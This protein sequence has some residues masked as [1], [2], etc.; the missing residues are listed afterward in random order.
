MQDRLAESRAVGAAIRQVAGYCLAL[1]LMAILTACGNRPGPQSLDPRVVDVPGARIVSMYVAT[2]R[3]RVAPGVNRFTDAPSQTLNFALYRVSIPPTHKP[4]QIEYPGDRPNPKTD[5]VVVDQKPLDKAE[6]LRGISR[7]SNGAK[8]DISLFVHGFNTS[9][10]EA[11]F[12][13]AQLTADSTTSSN[14][15]SVLFA[16]PSTASYSGYLADKAAAT[17][18]RDQLTEL[19]TLVTRERPTG[20]ILVAAH[21]MGGWL[22]M[23]AL[24]QLK[25]TGKQ[26]VLD[27]LKVILA[28]PDIDGMIFLA[29]MQVIGRMREPMTI[30]VSQDDIALSISSFISQDQMRIGLIN[31]ADPRVQEGAKEFNIQFI[32]ISEVKSDDP[33]H[34]NG[35][36]SLAALAPSV[37]KQKNARDPLQLNKAGV[38]VFDAVGRTLIAP[39]TIGKQL[40]AK[41]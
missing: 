41:K 35:F 16:W 26:A 6:F 24:R 36:A 8:G 12:R 29:Q 7:V 38:F 2:S 11:V 10:P 30:L 33:F 14:D 28:A 31:I 4:G 19:L 40:T 5:F 22:L 3:E 13:N 1:M 17:A 21:S 15:V 37:Q 34:H 18:S 23:E 39:F 32:D 25:L 20:Q 27:R 9:L